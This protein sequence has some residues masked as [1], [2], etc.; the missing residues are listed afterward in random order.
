MAVPEQNNPCPEPLTCSI[1]VEVARL[2]GEV[3]SELM[4]LTE[5]V[6]ALKSCSESAF[7]RGEKKMD[8]HDTRI[9]SLEKKIWWASGAASAISMAF[10]F[11]F[12]YIKRGG[13]ENG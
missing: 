4:A 11:V 8:G 2:R 3:T 13:G 10:T 7:S 9:D 12:P 1:A 5:N 6:K